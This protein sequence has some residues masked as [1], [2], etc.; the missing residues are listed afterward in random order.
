MG[1]V[2][3]N[4][5]HKV[6][7]EALPYIKNCWYVLC[8]RGPLMNDYRKLAESLGVSNRFIMPG[9]RSDVA[10]F[11]NIADVFVFPS[12]REGLP[13]S[14]M[15]AMAF[16]LPVICTKIRGN[17][18]LITEGK[19]GFFFHADNRF[20]LVTT[21]KEHFFER[22]ELAS[23]GSYNREEI[24]NYGQKKVLEQVYNLYLS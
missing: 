4:K 7:I 2:N 15:E 3:K 24:K 17:S 13:V 12:Y 22:C 19:G 16:G 5:N 1:E 11:Y 9:Y 8:G 21:L 18:D 14:V 10:N 23:L 6:I 20:E